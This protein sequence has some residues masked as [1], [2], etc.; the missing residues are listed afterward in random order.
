MPVSSSP[1]LDHLLRTLAAV[2]PG[3]RV[4]VLG[5]DGGRYVDALARLGF[6]VHA[7]V[8]TD[9]VARRVL[10]TA[11]EGERAGRAYATVASPGAAPYPEA[12]FDWV[13]VRCLGK[14]DRAARVQET[15]REVKDAGLAVRLAEARRLVRPGG[16]VFAV[17]PAA[18]TSDALRQ[19]AERAELA[20]AEAPSREEDGAALRAIYR[21]VEKGTPP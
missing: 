11:E 16:W 2:S 20:E 21:R 12:H 10:S 9:A 6:E 13:V 14:R 17:A 15:E 3:R 5:T 8:P 4:L 7:C 19:R 18:L 1:A